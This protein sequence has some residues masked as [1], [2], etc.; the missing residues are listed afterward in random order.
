MK[1]ARKKQTARVARA[2]SAKRVEE[3]V[4]VTLTSA[5]AV[6]K[7]PDPAFKVIYDWAPIMNPKVGE[8]IGGA[9]AES[10]ILVYQNIDPNAA[11]TGEINTDL[12]IADIERQRKTNPT[13]WGMLD[14]EF[15]FDEVLQAGPTHQLYDVCAKNMVHAIRTV[16]ERFPDVKWTYYGIP[17][18]SYWPGGKLWAFATP[19]SQRAEIERQLTGYGPVLKELDWYTP[20]FYDVYNVEA[21]PDQASRDAHMVNERE[22]RLARLGVIREFFARNN[23]EPRP[24]LPAVCPWFTGHGNTTAH[25]LIPDTELVR[26]Q[27]MPTVD[28]KCEGMAIWTAGFWYLQQATLPTNLSNKTQERVRVQFKKHFL[29][30][31]EPESWTSDEIKTLLTEKVGI[32][33]GNMAKLAYQASMK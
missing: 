1:N 3:P 6:P 30:N 4:Q 11:K 24:I 19:E 26:D 17:G 31:A 32:A 27:I 33:I 20:C 25:E 14:Y 28:G 16:K 22:Y 12:L 2:S 8:L 21:F 29:G 5:D 18:L 10:Y 23:M 9:K 15:P 7:K 13:G